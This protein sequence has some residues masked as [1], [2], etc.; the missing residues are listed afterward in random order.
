[1]NKK[2][3]ATLQVGIIL[4]VFIAVLVG[5]ILLTDVAGFV[6]T[7]RNTQT[8]NDTIDGTSTTTPANGATIDL[9]GQELLSTPIV[10]NASGTAETITSDNYTIAEGVSATTGLKTI[11]FTT[12]GTEIDAMAVNISYTYGADGYIESSGGR[13]IAGLIILFFA[14]GIGV[15]A[16]MPTMR[17]RLFDIIGK[18]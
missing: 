16:L 9:P 4:S 15:I 14:L 5:L 6:G 17:D 2:G 18:I 13:A 7:T 1:M 8:Q 3:Q 10:M 12:V 11:Q